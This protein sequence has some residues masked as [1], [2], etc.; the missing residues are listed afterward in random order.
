MNVNITERI[1]HM[2]TNQGRNEPAS[3]QT[4]NAEKR[5]RPKKTELEKLM[6]RL[7]KDLV[8]PQFTQKFPLPIVYICSPFRGSVGKNIA[9]AKLYSRYAISRCCLPVAP[10]L[11]YPRFLRDDV[12]SER[13]IGICCGLCLL[14]KCTEIWVFGEKLSQGMKR[15]LWRAKLRGKVIRRFTEDMKE[16]SVHE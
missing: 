4:V 7:E 15:E 1:E 13:E 16:V 11:L 5:G 9:K 8:I 3:M 14:D 12:E 6:G 2:E 10:H